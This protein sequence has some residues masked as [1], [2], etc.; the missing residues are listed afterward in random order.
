MATVAL[1]VAWLARLPTLSAALLVLGVVELGAI[2]LVITLKRRWEPLDAL[3]LTAASGVLAVRFVLWGDRAAGAGFAILAG[4]L[5]LWPRFIEARFAGLLD[6]AERL[7][8]RP[9]LAGLG[10]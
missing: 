9:G 1:S 8:S 5:A 2:A 4:S 6:M 10:G 7:I 3:T